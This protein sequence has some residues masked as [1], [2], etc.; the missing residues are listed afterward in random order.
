[1]SLIVAVYASGM[2]TSSSRRC[3]FDRRGSRQVVDVHQQ[4]WYSQVLLVYGTDPYQRQHEAI[5]IAHGPQTLLSPVAAC[6]V[7]AGC[8]VFTTGPRHCVS[9][10]GAVVNYMIAP[11]N[12]SHSIGEGCHKLVRAHLV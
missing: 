5:A 6:K 12:L 1:M 8:E 4:H 11:W 2:F 9:L 3:V 10:T 7:L